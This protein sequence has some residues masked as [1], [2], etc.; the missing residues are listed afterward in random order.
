MV[1][2]VALLHVD[3]SG[4]PERRNLEL[5]AESIRLAAEAGAKWIE[6]TLNNKGRLLK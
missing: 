5:L 2:K 6:I 3:V 1:M 4:G